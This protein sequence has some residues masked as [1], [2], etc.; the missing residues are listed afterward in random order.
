VVKE[1]GDWV[2]VCGWRERKREGGEREMDEC[3]EEVVEERNRA[4]KMK[5]KNPPNRRHIT[6]AL[7]E[8]MSQRLKLPPNPT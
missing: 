4:G 3:D 6:P 2:C 1:R 5:K 7:Y 8:T